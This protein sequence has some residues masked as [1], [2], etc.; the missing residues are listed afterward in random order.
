MSNV[1]FSRDMGFKEAEFLRIFPVAINGASYE[2]QGRRL[3]V[4]LDPGELTVVL[5]EQQYRKI[6]SISLPFL[7]VSFSFEGVEQSRIDQ[8]IR[9][10][11]LRYQRGGG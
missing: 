9:Y 10:F 7:N 6:A 2:M 3:L 11:D 4:Q 8:F 5:G 1:T